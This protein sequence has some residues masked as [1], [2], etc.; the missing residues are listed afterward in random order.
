MPMQDTS[1]HNILLRDGDFGYLKAAYPSLSATAVVRQLV[2]RH[3]DTL[4]SQ[5]PEITV[6]IPPEELERV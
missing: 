1:R 2:S 4:R 5:Q 6:H 3:V